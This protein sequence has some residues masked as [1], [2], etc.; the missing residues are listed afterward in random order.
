M[1]FDCLVKIKDKKWEKRRIPAKGFKVEPVFRTS[2]F[3]NMTPLDRFFTN[4]SCN[5]LA[6]RFAINW[7]F[8]TVECLFYNQR[9]DFRPIWNEKRS[10]FIFVHFLKLNPESLNCHTWRTDLKIIIMNGVNR[11]P[12][13]QN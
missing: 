1:M 12:G 2:F 10:V 3:R 9:C 5:F 13:V 6:F 11:K 8:I 4:F 7:M